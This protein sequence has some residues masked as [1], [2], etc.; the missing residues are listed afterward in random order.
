MNLPNRH[1]QYHATPPDAGQSLLATW[2]GS[3]EAAAQAR[4]EIRR[5][6]RAD[7]IRCRAVALHL[8]CRG[9][10]TAELRSLRDL[11]RSI[12][13]LQAELPDLISQQIADEVPELHKCLHTRKE[14]LRN[15]AQASR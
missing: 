7:A 13:E 9:S 4:K 11:R 15:G 5:W 12:A 10:N 6:Q 8:V 14:V 2:L 3:E 1:A